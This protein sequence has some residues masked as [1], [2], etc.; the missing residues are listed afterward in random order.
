MLTI[1][2]VYSSHKL[3]KNRAEAEAVVE[4]WDENEYNINEDP[5]GSGRC[6]IEILDEETGD[7]IGKL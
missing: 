1:S 2:M 4:G 5:L 3:F 7:V 6:F